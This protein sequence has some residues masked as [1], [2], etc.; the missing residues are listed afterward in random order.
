MGEILQLI[1]DPVWQFWGALVAAVGIVVAM[2]IFWWSR[3]RKD[4]AYELL[5]FSPL[6]TEKGLSTGKVKIL[7]NGQ[8]ADQVHLVEVKIVNSGSVPVLAEDMLVPIGFTF[9]VDARVLTADPFDTKPTNLEAQ[10]DFDEDRITL[11]PMLLNAHDE[12]GVRALIADAKGEGS[13]S[14]I[15]RVVGVSVIRKRDPPPVRR[16]LRGSSIAMVVGALTVFAIQSATGR[17]ALFSAAMSLGLLAAGLLFV[18]VQLIAVR[19]ETTKDSTHTD[20][21]ST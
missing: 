1:R 16:W 9:G 3:Q 18:L 6:L 7:V 17:G 2:L 12:V 5:T 4:L 14:A 20:A 13:V 10:L 8:E 19:R 15:G 11:R 21:R